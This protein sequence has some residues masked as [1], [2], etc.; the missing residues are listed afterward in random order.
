MRKVKLQGVSPAETEILRLVWQLERATVQGVCDRLPAKRRIAYATVQTL[1]RRLE[2]KGY[3]KH[4]VEG[5]AH[6]FFPAVKRDDVVKRSVGDFIERLFG[7]DP[8][9]LVQHLAEHGQITTDDIERLRRLIGE[10]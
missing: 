8:I 4:D 10:K 9:P 6:V 3:V 2:A 5:K 7:G 1:L